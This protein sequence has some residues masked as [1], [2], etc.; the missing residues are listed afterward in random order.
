LA[1]GE[2]RRLVQ[3]GRCVMAART[4]R[5]RSKRRCWAA[6]LSAGQ[7][8][9]VLV[10]SGSELR[11]TRGCTER[12]AARL[13]VRTR[14]HVYGTYTIPS[15]GATLPVKLARRR[16]WTLTC[17]ANEDEKLVLMGFLQRNRA[18][19]KR[20]GHMVP[21]AGGIGKVCTK[22][23]QVSDGPTV[24]PTPGSAKLASTPHVAHIPICPAAGQNPAESNVATQLPYNPLRPAASA[25]APQLAYNP[26][27]P[28]ASAQPASAKA[29]VLPPPP[30]S[31]GSI[32]GFDFEDSV[33]GSG[34]C[35]KPG[36]RV[37]VKFDIKVANQKESAER[38]E[39]RFRVG[40]SD[41]L[42]GWVDGNV[43]IEEVLGVW[44][45]GIEGMMTGGRRR[46]MIPSNRGFRESGGETVPKGSRCF[47]DVQLKKIG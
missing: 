44:G 33:L 37:L 14:T 35:V 16:R 46:I 7:S 29:K 9:E 23:R 13:E 20:I 5:R 22:E 6:V 17:K 2:G 11:I 10:T 15:C 31:K 21:S 41:T 28:V 38:G 43:D 42:D 18:Q 12:G 24:P 36:Q 4:L 30:V 40:D 3:S 34:E 26:L 32:A 19:M 45:R 8:L 1:Q 25:T 27:R 39:I 47:F